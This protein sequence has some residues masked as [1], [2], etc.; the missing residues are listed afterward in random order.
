MLR[1][2][3]AEGAARERRAQLIV[4]VQMGQHE[5]SQLGIVQEAELAALVPLVRS[6]DQP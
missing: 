3:V 2:H 6:L 1:H 5:A 4:F